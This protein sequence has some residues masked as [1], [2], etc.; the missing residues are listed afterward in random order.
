MDSSRTNVIEIKNLTT[1]YGG[2]KGIFDISFVIKKGEV[3][4]FL[5]P[6]GAGKTTTIRHLMGFLK[7]NVGSCLI[8][9]L[10]C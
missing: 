6:N 10:D 9:G 8:D 4:G 2:G 3:F 1:D 7:N 5:G